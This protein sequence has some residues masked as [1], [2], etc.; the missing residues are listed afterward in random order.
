MKRIFFVLMAICCFVEFTFAG[1]ITPF[2]ERFSLYGYGQ[3]SFDSR[4]VEDSSNMSLKTLFLNPLLGIFFDFK[5]NGNASVMIEPRLVMTSGMVAEEMLDAQSLGGLMQEGSDSGT[6]S[7]EM[8]MDMQMAHLDLAAMTF[9]YRFSDFVQVRAG[10][11]Y[12]PYGLFGEI[13]DSRILLPFSFL[14]HVYRAFPENIPYPFSYF[15]MSV[16]GFVVEGHNENL[17]YKLYVSNGREKWSQSNLIGVFGPITDSNNDKGVGVRLSYSL[18]ESQFAL[19]AYTDENSQEDNRRQTSTLLSAKLHLGNL[20]FFGE[21]GTTLFSKTKMVDTVQIGWA[22]YTILKYGLDLPGGQ[23]SPIIGFDALCPNYKTFD[24]S[25]M[26]ILAGL[27]YRPH[28]DYLLRLNVSQ[29]LPT[30]EIMGETYITL[31]LNYAF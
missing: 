16:I 26:K 11:F 3:F 5:I 6:I 2:S 10:K 9:K 13:R 29:S 14:P 21:G 4:I 31:T 17:G 23:I 7:H 24:D 1:D 28:L 22:G 20:E 30:S 19:S 27:E 15:P 8:L 18:D 12:T 25:E